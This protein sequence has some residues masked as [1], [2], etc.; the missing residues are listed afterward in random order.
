MA[1]ITFLFG[2][3]ASADK[4]PVVQ[5]IPHVMEKTIDFI[6]Q[7][8]FKLS[9]SDNFENRL[10]QGEP[11]SKQYYLELLISELKWLKKMS[12]THASIDTYA[13][14]LSI[15]GS[16]G[17]LRRLK[18]AAS[19]F[20]AI[21]QVRTEWSE[22]RIDPRY[23]SFFASIMDS[24][25]G[26][27]ENLNVV[28]WNYDFQFEMA[29]MEYSNQYKDIDTAGMGLNVKSKF[30][31]KRRTVGF[32]I[33]KLNGSASF[34]SPDGQSRHHFVDTFDLTLNEDFLNKLVEQYA[35]FSTN[36]EL[37]P[38]LSFAWENDTH[39]LNPIVQY[40][41]RELRQTEIL[42]IIGYSFPF[43]NRNVDKQIL[44]GMHQLKKIYY[45][46][47]NADKLQSRLS[48]ILNVSHIEVVP[49]KEVGQFFIPYEF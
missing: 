28:S 30:M 41:A 2:A 49:Y 10:I 29:Y 8:K 3:G 11:K 16:F 44:G 6:Q 14:K 40:S 42:V 39:S 26:L 37:I 19:A 33:M 21:N 34:H 20:F 18:I 12:M 27:P 15:T 43:F 32:S 46:D 35:I 25:M 1:Y 22:K 23:D 4:L 36:T 5:A 17:E 47:L 31:G 7:E 48:A 38:S 9:N 13:K 45:Q 24:E